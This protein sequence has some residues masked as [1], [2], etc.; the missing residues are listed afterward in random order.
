MKWSCSS[1]IEVP[2]RDSND[3]EIT[4]RQ[5]I[6]RSRGNSVN[7]GIQ[8]QRRAVK[9]QNQETGFNISRPESRKTL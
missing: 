9:G 8:D 4:V 1:F 3:R 6:N 5:F 2:Q 7:D